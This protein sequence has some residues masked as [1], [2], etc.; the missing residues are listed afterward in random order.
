MYFFKF[1]T[2]SAVPFWWAQKFQQLCFQWYAVKA[3][4]YWNK[5][6]FRNMHFRVLVLRT[7]SAIVQ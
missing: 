5:Y 2:G 3:I 7:F 6:Y 4:K 1:V